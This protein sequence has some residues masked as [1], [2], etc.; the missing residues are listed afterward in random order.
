MKK[1]LSCIL[2]QTRTQTIRKPHCQFPDKHRPLEVKTFQIFTRRAWER[3]FCWPSYG[4]RLWL[5]YPGDQC[6]RTAVAL[7]PTKG[8]MTSLLE[9][10]AHTMMNK[11]TIQKEVYPLFADTSFGLYVHRFGCSVFLLHVSCVVFG[12]LRHLGLTR[13]WSKVCTEN[14]CTVVPWPKWKSP[15]QSAFVISCG[16]GR[17]FFSVS[18]RSFLE[19]H[20][21]CGHQHLPQMPLIIAPSV[22]LTAAEVK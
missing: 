13:K 17:L 22:F 9:R 5:V 8:M 11:H 2:H 3:R 18:G 21:I 6:P 19:L 12:I 15:G 1:C 7:Y 14:N 4:R 10:W 16:F 20:R